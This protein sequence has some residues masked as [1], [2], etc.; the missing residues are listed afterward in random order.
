MESSSHFPTR[1]DAA[2]LLLSLAAFWGSWA[3]ALIAIR[4]AGH[5]M[6]AAVLPMVLL[7]LFSTA[8]LEI[9]VR[10]FHTRLTGKPLPP[11]PFGSLGMSRSMIKAMAPSTLAEAGIRVGL[12]GTL[13]A[14]FVYAVMAI[15]LVALGTILS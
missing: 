15:D 10:R 11:W 13:A 7:V 5:V 4:L 1:E 9:S 2:W 14:G 8:I 12:S 3:L 6:S